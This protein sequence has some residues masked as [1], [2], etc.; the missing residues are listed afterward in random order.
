[1]VQLNSKILKLSNMVTRDDV[2]DDAEHLDIRDDVSTECATFGKVFQ[3]IIPRVKDGFPAA[4]EG[5][6]FVEFETPYG[7]AQAKLALTGRK[8]ADNIVVVEYVS[9]W[10]VNG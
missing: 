5:T 3:V 7:A 1:M 9:D 6:I 4:T 10:W 8:F 2:Q